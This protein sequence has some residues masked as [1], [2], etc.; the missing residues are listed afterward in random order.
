MFSLIQLESFVAVAEELHFGAAAERLNMTQPPLSRQIQLLERELQAKLFIRNSR[1][2]ELTPAGRV[3]LPNARR[4]LDLSHKTS[5]EVSRVASG[6]SGTVVVGY[7]AVAGQSVLPQLLSTAARK[8]PHVTLVLREAVS[9]E[10]LDALSRG[11]ID[12]GLLRPVVNRSGVRTHLVKKDRLVVALP[13]GHHLAT[14]K[15]VLIKEIVGLP[16]M[17]YSTNEARYFYDL[18]LRLFDSVSAKP[19]IAQIASQIPALMALVAADLGVSLV[20]ASAMDFAPPNV[21]FEELVG[22]KGLKDLNHSDMYLAWDD[23]SANPAAETLRMVFLESIGESFD[24][25]ETDNA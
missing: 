21:V 18:V 7:T 3:L 11:T 9:V 8:L 22:P 23:S 25:A 2:V 24:E 12:I 10:Q 17:M 6:E 20:P 1:N 5:L 14:G 4:L 15:G 16:L 19:S 13:K